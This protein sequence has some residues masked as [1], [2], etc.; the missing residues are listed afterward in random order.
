VRFEHQCSSKVFREAAGEEDEADKEAENDNRE[1]NDDE[2]GS[3]IEYAEEA[4]VQQR[5]TF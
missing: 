1:D 2:E 3:D 5:N 4:A